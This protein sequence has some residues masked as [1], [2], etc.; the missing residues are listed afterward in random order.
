VRSSLEPSFSCFLRDSLRVSGA[1]SNLMESLLMFPE[2]V[3]VVVEEAV[4][5]ETAATSLA[6]TETLLDSIL[7]ALLLE[8]R[9]ELS[10]V[11]LIFNDDFRVLVILFMG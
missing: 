2:F 11:V 7:N 1:V 3:I 6:L 4:L 10:F 9:S 8:T 5:V